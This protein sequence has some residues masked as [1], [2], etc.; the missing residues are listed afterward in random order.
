MLRLPALL[1][2]TVALIAGC[3][4]EYLRPGQMVC[5]WA[6]PIRPSRADQLTDGTARQILTHNETG[7]RLCGGQ[8]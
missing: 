6:A 4:T 1:I 2:A 3:A 8:P 5:D 7:A